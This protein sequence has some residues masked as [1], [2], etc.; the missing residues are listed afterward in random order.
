[1]RIRVLLAED[2]TIVRQG[3]R[4]L[5]DNATDIEV[6]AAVSNG[7]DAVEAARKLRPDVALLDI[8][9]PVLNGLEAVPQIALV[10]P[11]CKIL[12]LSSYSDE[13]RVRDLIG[14]GI[15]GYLVKQTA[16]SELIEAIRQANRG[17]LYFSP[18]I[19]RTLVE[20][21]RNCVPA[22]A[23]KPKKKQHLTPREK[24]VLIL[25][26]QGSPNK[27]IALDLAISMKTVEKH[28]QQVMNKLD[29]HEGAS[30]TRYAL[31]NRMI[32]PSGVRINSAA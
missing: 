5:L 13:D 16:S 2:H 21:G 4:L 22:Q 18:A 26:A 19:S 6:V 15:A 14:A 9:M 29:L 7:R 11:Q 31:S 10:A 32:D 28:R 25:V 30:L 8:M 23:F 17:N 1:M 3:L 12:M 27:A 24:Q 20:Y